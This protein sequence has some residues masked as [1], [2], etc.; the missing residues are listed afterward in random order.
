M[1][2]NSPLPVLVVPASTRYIDPTRRILA[3]YG[4]TIQDMIGRCH[5]IVNVDDEHGGASNSFFLLHLVANCVKDFNRIL[6]VVPSTSLPGIYH[7]VQ[8]IVSANPTIEIDIHVV[9]DPAGHTVGHM[10]EPWTHYQILGTVGAKLAVIA[11][12]T[13][14]I[15]LTV[16][17]AQ[18]Q[19]AET[20]D[21]EVWPYGTPS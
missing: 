19:A 21:E 17:E 16:R 2:S 8:T 5:F 3:Q 7:M 13:N 14:W 10:A 9:S 20:R 1:N 15:R 4:L 12:L 6:L 18:V 11:G